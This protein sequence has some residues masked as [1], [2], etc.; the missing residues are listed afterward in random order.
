MKI[1]SSKTLAIKAAARL[2]PQYADLVHDLQKTNGRISFSSEI[3]A[4]QNYIGS[5]V[6]MYDDERKIGRA[7]LL[8]LMGADGYKEFISD[9]NALS[10]EDQQELINEISVTEDND[11]VE[12]FSEF[13]IPSTPEEW[14]AGRDDLAKLPEEERKEIEKRSAYF[15]CFF[16][17]SFFNTLSLMVHG[18][19]LTTLIPQAIAGDD[20]AFLKAI[21][22]DRMLLIHYPYFRERKIR[23]QNDGETEFLRSI[24]Y[25]ESN[26]PVRGKIEYPALYMLFG[27]L[28]S[29]QWLDDLKHKEILNICDDAGLDRYQN[30]IEDVGYLTKRLS[31]YRRYQKT[32]GLSMH[33]N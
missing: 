14:Q 2:T 21:Q 19:R 32:G 12:A 10:P 27:V 7:V 5:Y 6:L 28:D 15:W 9:I 30:R 26:P 3:L 4:I 8:V 18:A 17:S 25:R 20:E 23:A 29:F 24:S 22:I 1:R 11:L 16:F 13:Q 31:E 33:S